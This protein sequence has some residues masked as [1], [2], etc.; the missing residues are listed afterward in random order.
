MEAVFPRNPATTTHRV[1]IFLETAMRYKTTSQ[2]RQPTGN[3]CAENNQVVL[4]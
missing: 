4:K 2:E 1:G 3:N